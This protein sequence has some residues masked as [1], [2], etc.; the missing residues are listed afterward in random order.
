VQSDLVAHPHD[1]NSRLQ[2]VHGDLVLHLLL[3]RRDVVLLRQVLQDDVVLLRQLRLCDGG[4]VIP[5]WHVQSLWG[6]SM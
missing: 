1:R 4:T 2:V 6:F 3:R 5:H